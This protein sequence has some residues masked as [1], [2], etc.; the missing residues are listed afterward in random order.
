MGEEVGGLCYILG[1]EELSC[2]GVLFFRLDIHWFFKTLYVDEV[3]PDAFD[4]FFDSFDK[5]LKNIL[6]G[7]DVDLFF[8]EVVF[9]LKVW[10]SV[11]VFDHA[12]VKL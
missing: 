7:E 10:V 3:A 11:V 12:E 5:V 2:F 1:G 6:L 9:D 4:L 8:V